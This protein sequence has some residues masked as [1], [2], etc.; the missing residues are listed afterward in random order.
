MEGSLRGWYGATL[1]LLAILVV[2][3]IWSVEYPPLVDY[4]NHLA[5]GYILYH[6]DDVPTFREDFDV[7]YLSTASLAMDGFILALLPICDARTTGKLFLTLTLWL[8]LLG[9]H[10]LG[11]TLHGQPTWLALGGAL[12]AYHSMFFYGFTN[13][14]FSLGIFLLATAAWVAWRDGWSWWRLAIVALLALGCY[15]SHMA[16]FIFFTGTVLAMTAWQIVVERKLSIGMLVGFVPILLPLIFFFGFRSRGSE[17]GIV[18]NSVAGKFVGALTLVRSYD[19]FLDGGFLVALMIFA[20]FLFAWSART[21][22]QGGALFAGLGCFVM[23]LIGPYEIFGGAPGDARF[24]LPAAALIV[25]SFD[26]AYARGKAIALLTMFLVLVIFRIGMI[27]FYWHGMDVGLR[28]Q[29]ALFDAFPEQARVYPLI[30]L[31]DDADESKRDRPVFHVIHYAVIDRHIYSPHLFAFPGQQPMHYKTKPIA[32][33]HGVGDF[34]ALDPVKLHQ[35]LANY[36]YLWCYRLPDD[37][38]QFLQERC[39][40]MAEKGPGSVWRVGKSVK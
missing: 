26:F 30:R 24:L 23:F 18:W 40:L 4:P 25:L 2:V 38:R 19:R 1:T 17:S 33:H 21:R 32:F 11:A 22:V 7:D 3:P 15:F 35:V 6:H 9:W 29:I 27:A 10:C 20:V 39:T 5:R 34:P 36:D 12:F 37:Y 13:F 31:A 28:E 8:W 16:A 14:S